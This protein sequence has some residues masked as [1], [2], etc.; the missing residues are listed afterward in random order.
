MLTII[1]CGTLIDGTGTPPAAGMAVAIEENR[2]KAVGKEEDFGSQMKGSN[3]I[4]ADGKWVLPGLINVHEHLIMQE[5][6]GS[7]LDRMSQSVVEQS[8]NAIRNAIGHPFSRFP[9]HPTTSGP[10]TGR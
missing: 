7:P 1:K 6:Q 2:I 4:E 9:S 8:A 3:V 5:V 10:R